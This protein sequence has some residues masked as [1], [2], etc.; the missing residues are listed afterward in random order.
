MPLTISSSET[1]VKWSI[2]SL[3]NSKVIEPNSTPPAVPSDSV[4][5]EG[6]SNCLLAL[7]DSYMTQEL[8][9]DTP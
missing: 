6:R 7:I 3:H 1:T 2:T 9:G 4:G 5:F 8:I